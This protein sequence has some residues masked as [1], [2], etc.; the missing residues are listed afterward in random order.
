MKKP[1]W[2]DEAGAAV[3]QIEVA[4][5]A[6]SR[7]GLYLTALLLLEARRVGEYEL[8]A[9]VAKHKEFRRKRAKK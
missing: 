2:V 1:K 8:C 6:L 7:T 9:E 4:R 5:K 3:E